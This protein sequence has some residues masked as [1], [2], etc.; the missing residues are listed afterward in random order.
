MKKY[1]GILLAFLIFGIEDICA[2]SETAISRIVLDF[3]CSKDTSERY[4]DDIA[5]EAIDYYKINLQR[6][7]YLSLSNEEKKMWRIC[8][9]TILVYQDRLRYETSSRFFKSN[10]CPVEYASSTFTKKDIENKL[11]ETGVPKSVK[12][13]DDYLDWLMGIKPSPKMSGL[14]NDLGKAYQQP[15]QYKD[16]DITFVKEQV[17]TR[18]FYRK[19]FFAEY[20]DDMAGV[21]RGFLKQV[22]EMPFEEGKEK[23]LNW[24]F[25]PLQLLNHVLIYYA[26]T[27]DLE[28][29][30]KTK[31]KI[32]NIQELENF[33]ED[34][35]V[36]MNSAKACKEILDAL[37]KSL[38]QW[39]DFFKDCSKGSE[40]RLPNRYLPI[41][42]LI[43]EY[44][45][46]KY[47]TDKM[48]QN[49]GEMSSKD[50]LLN[51]MIRRYSEYCQQRLGVFLVLDILSN[52]VTREM[53]C[54]MYSLLDGTAA[55]FK[56]FE[57]QIVSFIDHLES[58]KV[59]SV[60]VENKIDEILEFYR[61]YTKNQAFWI[62]QS[63]EHKYR[64]LDKNVS[65][66]LKGLIC[67][68]RDKKS[69]FDRKETQRCLEKYV[70]TKRGGNAEQDA[71]WIERITSLPD[72]VVDGK[73]SY[74][75][76]QVTSL[77]NYVLELLQ[78]YRQIESRE[79]K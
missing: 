64:R 23:F 71:L 8:L 46:W 72:C 4:L 45:K 50:D 14:L 29:L 19:S 32:E 79:D 68:F 11:I 47:I 5:K 53:L 18:R 10:E 57:E 73:E 40:E 22:D 69:V 2:Q 76:R 67:H 62:L 42:N 15:Q 55:Q 28:L 44:N 61:W 25:E 65:E 54:W 37:K 70:N 48:E 20:Y 78:Y 52:S 17:A 66:N 74:P 51:G 63:Y 30:E 60:D 38:E 56:E 6:R 36:R 12:G 49:L 24:L 77:E 39:D 27:R 26:F 3:N 41:M 34:L 59:L 33:E 9:L 75:I 7:S 21:L 35:L 13:E 43:G 1:V 58:I 31:E 16:F